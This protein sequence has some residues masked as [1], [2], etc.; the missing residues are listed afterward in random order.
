MPPDAA[1]GTAPPQQLSREGQL[2]Q[3]QQQQA[4]LQAQQAQMMSARQQAPP[5]RPPP[6]PELN[7]L[8]I[9]AYLDQ[10]VVPILLDGE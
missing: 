7:N 4:Q 3:L 1:G 6:N 5:S 2:A 10:T 9:R 8:P